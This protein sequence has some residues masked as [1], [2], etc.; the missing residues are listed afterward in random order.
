M[1]YNDPDEHSAGLAEELLRRYLS[2]GCTLNEAVEYAN[3]NFYGESVII[4][5]KGKIIDEDDLGY[6]GQLDTGTL[7]DYLLQDLLGDNNTDSDY[8]YN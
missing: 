3:K 1:Y 6:G 5:S 4:T 8:Y 2:L 7:F